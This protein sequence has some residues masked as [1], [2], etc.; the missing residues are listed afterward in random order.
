MRRNFIILLFSLLFLFGCYSASNLNILNVSYLYNN[1]SS[2]SDTKLLVWHNEQ[3]SSIV[4]YTLDLNDFLYKSQ[5]PGEVPSAEFSVRYELFESYESDVVLDSMIVFFSDTNYYGKKHTLLESFNIP[6]RYDNNYLLKIIISDIN[7]GNAS[8]TFLSIYKKNKYSSQNFLLQ[9]AD[10]TPY[11]EKYLSSKRSVR[12]K[13]SDVSVSKLFVRYYNRDFPIASP[14]FVMD[15]HTPFNY[16]ADSVFSIELS[17]IETDEL[18]FEKKGFYHIQIDTNRRA[19]LTIFNFFDDFPEITSTQQILEPVRY[20]TTKKEFG[21]LS[22]SANVKMAI[23]SFWIEHSGSR[24]R[25]RT[26]ISRYYNRVEEANLFFTSYLE[27]WKSDRGIMYIIYGQ[28]NIV[29]R[30]SD[31]ETW[32]YGEQGNLLSIK[33]NFSKVINPFTDNDYILTK[34]PTY[35]EGWYNAVATWR[36]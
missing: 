36:R 31:V 4:Y 26:Q 30:S 11:F 21:I 19:G 16:A 1:S 18:Y 22:S 23:D 9:T 29:Y 2:F 3:N 33:L 32:I 25:A 6:A 15:D 10:G 17:G 5:K 28:P 14:P 35:K 20:L 8:S 27:G 13:L 24:E 34:S 12:I 7:R